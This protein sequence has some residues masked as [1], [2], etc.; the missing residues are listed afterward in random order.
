MKKFIS[1]SFTLVFLANISVGQAQKDLSTWEYKPLVENGRDALTSE[2]Y[3]S[4]LIYFKTA[5]K[6]KQTSVLSTLRAA[7]CGYS[8]GDKEYYEQQIE[9][10]F[11]LDWGS[12]KSIY[13]NFEEFAYLKD[14]E[15]DKKIYA[16]YD[17]ALDTSGV[18]RALMEEFEMIGETDQRYRREMRPISEKYGWDSPQMDSMWAL[19]NPIDS[20]N[21]LRICAIIDSCGYPGKSVV[22]PGQASTAFMVIQHAD[23]EVQEKYLD[24]ITGAAD[25][26]EVRWSSVALLVDRI[27]MRNGT[28]QIYGSQINTDKETNEYY[29]AE[30]AEPFNI[31]SIRA[32]VGLPPLQAYADNWNFTWDPQKHIAR[33]EKIKAEAIKEKSETNK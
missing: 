3:D 13:E 30:I 19:Q 16:L 15:F 28:P 12:S 18:N 11:S 33:H 7:A 27:N 23:L 21:T 22:G 29:F 14:T 8:G 10:A 32:T 25:R 6:I 5:F 4:C 20:A 17:H 31:D 1:V 2:K 24:V 9:K 26:A